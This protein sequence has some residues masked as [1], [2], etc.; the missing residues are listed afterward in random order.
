VLADGSNAGREQ[1]VGALAASDRA[2]FTADA[3]AARSADRAEWASQQA[4]GA[5]NRITDALNRVLDARGQGVAQ[6]AVKEEAPKDIA[7]R[8]GDAAESPLMRAAD[9]VARVLAAAGGTIYD[10]SGGHYGLEPVDA[11]DLRR[12]RKREQRA[13]RPVATVES[14]HDGDTAAARA[15]RGSPIPLLVALAA[16]VGAVGVAYSQRGKLRP[17][18]DQLMTRLPRQ[19]TTM[20]EPRVLNVPSGPPTPTPSFNRV[21]SGQL[22]ESQPPAAQRATPG[23]AVATGAGA[24]TINSDV[25]TGAGTPGGAGSSRRHATSGDGTTRTYTAGDQTQPKQP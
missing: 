4:I 5:A 15:K 18:W 25:A 3:R 21:V 22:M 12:E 23:R 6:V 7:I 13:A 16:G 20:P 8:V 9:A 2:A 24:T 14:H 10:Y 1:S 19:Y 11:H 17:L